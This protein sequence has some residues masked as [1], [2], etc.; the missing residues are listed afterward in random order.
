MRLNSFYPVLMTKNV[1][2]TSAF[3]QQY[4]GF[5]VVFEAGWYMSLKQ[6]TTGDE[7]AILQAAHETVPSAFGKSVQGLI[8][9]FEV[10]NVD[11]MYQHLIKEK[12]LPLHLDLRDEAFGQR[13]FIT[14]DPNGVLIDIIMVIPPDKSFLEHYKLETEEQVSQ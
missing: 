6:E 1:K 2:E 3:Y 11:E 8:L 7:L 9:N 14:S 13:H 4:F 12:K 10:D 5:S